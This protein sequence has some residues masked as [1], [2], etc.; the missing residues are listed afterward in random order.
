MNKAEFV[1]V[2]AARTNSS[3]KHAAE[4]V[5]AF[6][7]TVGEVLMQGE[8]VQFAGFGTFDVKVR[9]AR[10]GRNPRKPEETIKIPE[11]K[12]PT[13]KAGKTLKDNLNH[14]G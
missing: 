8:K 3:Q 5:D 14:K 13:F 11:A 2:V 9:R 10:E 6:M 1:A 7:D 4:M 12:V